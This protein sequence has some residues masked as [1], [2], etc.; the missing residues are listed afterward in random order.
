MRFVETGSLKSFIF[1]EVGG[2]QF[3]GIAFSGK[4]AAPHF[5]RSGADTGSANAGLS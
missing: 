2:Q 1:V 3:V 5:D 4:S